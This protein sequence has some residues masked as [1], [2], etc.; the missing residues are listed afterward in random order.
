MAQ[1]RGTFSWSPYNGKD[2]NAFGE[3]FWGSPI[4]GNYQKFGVRTD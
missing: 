2:S 3:S 4:S 1:I